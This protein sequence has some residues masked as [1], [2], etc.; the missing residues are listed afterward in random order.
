MNLYERDYI[1]VPPTSDELQQYK[2]ILAQENDDTSLGRKNL[3][4][5]YPPA[6]RHCNSLFPN[7]HIELIDFRLETIGL[8]PEVM[9]L[10]EEFNT[11]IHASDT[12]EQDILNFIN[13]KT[14][15]F[16]P[17]S[18]LVDRFP[19]GHHDLYLF[20]EFSLGDRT[21]PRPDYMLIGSGSGGYEFVLIEF[22]KSNGRITLKSGHY[23]EAIRKGNFQ[24]YD[25]QS[26]IDGNATLFYEKLSQLAYG[27]E[28]PPEFKKYDSSRFHYVTVA[29]LRDDFD[30]V[31]YRR[32]REQSKKEDIIT[33]HYDNL[34]DSALKLNERISF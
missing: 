31:T 8:K 12:N 32:R 33:L 34:Y 4:Y 7:N 23:G 5:L 16:I 11:L 9:K 17:A 18:I 21:A 27:K 13:H 29:G 22:E 3:R 19:F 25:W 26:W 14:A 24:I 10:L 2:R 6:I 15:Y 30:E 1:K 28:L 20:P